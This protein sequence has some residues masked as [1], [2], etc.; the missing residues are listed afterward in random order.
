MKPTGRAGALA[1]LLFPLIH[2]ALSAHPDEFDIVVYGGTSGGITAAVQAAKMGKKVVLVSPTAHLGGL[3][4]SGLGWTD[5]GS[6]AILGG[7][8]RDFYHRV[9]VHYSQQP[10][11]TSIRNLSGQGTAA[12]NHTTQV[13]SIFEPKVAE[14]VFNEMLSEWNVPVFTG[15]L[16][17][18]DGVVMDGLRITGL[19]MEGGETYRGKM[20]IDASYEGDV[21]AGAG[22]SWFIG[23]EANAVYGEDNSGV[24]VGKGSH[25]FT[26]N[27]ASISAYRI[28]G[29]PASGLLPGIEPSVATNGTADHRLQAYCFRMCLTDR[30]DNR[31]MVAQPPGYDA[32]NYELLLRAVEAGQGNN[33]FKLDLMPNRKTDSNNT[34]AVSTDYI[35]RNYGPGWNWATLN[36]AQRTALAKEHENW[37]RGL[38]WTL[39]NH[40]RVRA[41][42]P[43]GLYPTWGLPK[44]EFTDNGNWPYQLYVREARRMVSDYVMSTKNCRGTE[45]APDSV[46]MAAYTMDSHHVQRYVN[47]NGFV[48]NEGDV[49]DRTNGPYPISYR[50]IVPKQGECENLLVPW[51]L[52]SS[53]MA[54]GSIRME[55]VFMGL[56]QSSATA[57]SIAIDDGLT[58]Q[59]VPYAKL[60]VKMRA[61]RQALTTGSDGGAGT[62]TIVDNADD[63]AIKIGQWTESTSQSG[64][65][66]KDYLTDGNTGQGTKSVRFVPNLPASGSYTV[67]LR[68]PAQA[69]R[70]KNVPVTVFH[71][72]GSHF[73]RIDQEQN[74]NTWVSMGSFQF[75]AGSSNSGSLLIETTGADEYVIADA[76]RWVMPG[77]DNI[78]SVTPLIPSTMR[79]G[80]VPAEFIVSRNG[81]LDAPLVVDLTRGGTASPAE[82]SPSFP[83]SVTIPAGVGELV[84]PVGSPAVAVP[85]GER[86]VTVTINPS[87]GY[88]LG[89]DISATVKL[90]DPPFDAW[91]FSRFDA[92][93][94]AD[95][96]ISGPGA[97]P[98]GDGVANLVEFFSGAAGPDARPRLLSQD[99]KLYFLLRRHQRANGMKM[100]VWESDNLT[101]WQRVPALA[102][103]SL[104]QAAGDFRHIGIPV[105]GSDPFSDGKK[106][107]QLRIGE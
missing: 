48:R 38:I 79:G 78:V 57:A 6:T 45:V 52:S 9:Y 86:T 1:A 102:S 7:L 4:S 24:Q 82:L 101:G 84:V 104:F 28:A 76:A 58:V 70:A 73:V 97:D 35:G 40:P 29:N 19:R 98:D 25:N 26:N 8:S 92:A 67:Y 3:T 54:F 42:H 83:S 72:G 105:R 64:Y 59:Q 77:P 68:W 63:N 87:S 32:A 81:T 53:H 88:F 56:G 11:W 71:N 33:F 39:Q 96:Q 34:G 51:C 20:F 13:A 74:S 14:A 100:E 43:D 27:L 41:R 16:D 94:L 44:D 15:L 93:Q 65:Y 62:G 22:V 66:G 30:A 36:H 47:A 85:S 55:P 80:R 50:S 17:L 10:N 89:T 69:N 95:P 61:D 12:F 91:R 99:G 21:M 90:V 106:F 49:Q 75:N 60:V 107:F 23:R 18:D 103:P 2:G 46:G 5:L 31:V 37:Q